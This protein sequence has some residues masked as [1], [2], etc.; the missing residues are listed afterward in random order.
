MQLEKEEAMRLDTDGNSVHFIW[1]LNGLLQALYHA[2]KLGISFHRFIYAEHPQLLQH[3]H[4][5]KNVSV[6]DLTI[7]SSSPSLQ[8]REPTQVISAQAEI[9]PTFHKCC[10]KKLPWGQG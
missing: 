2:T 6:V 4:N 1:L 3:N 5:L 9:F 7:L 10:G 8:S